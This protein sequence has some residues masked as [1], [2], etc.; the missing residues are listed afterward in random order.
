[1]G[2]PSV[3]GVSGRH[4]Q[5]R[6]VLGPNADRRSR[7]LVATLGLPGE[8]TP[9]EERAKSQRNPSEGSIGRCPKSQS[10]SNVAG[11]YGSAPR[12]SASSAASVPSLPSTVSDAT[13]PSASVVPRAGVT[14]GR[15]WSGVGYAASL[16]TTAA[17]TGSALHEKRAERLLKRRP[18]RGD[19][20][21]AP[22][23]WLAPAGRGQAAFHLDSAEIG[24][25]YMGDRVPPFAA[26]TDSLP[27]QDGALVAARSESAIPL[28]TTGIDIVYR[29]MVQGTG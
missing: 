22:A 28:I 1:M 21:P 24:C 17:H 10:A 16:G 20:A 2:T 9:T 15:P 4:A 12:A 11:S 6:K 23:R 26:H 29:G 18:K 8:R 27:N 25:A 7:D 19:A 3:A 13:R 5:V 14:L